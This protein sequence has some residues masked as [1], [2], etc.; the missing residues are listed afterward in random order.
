MG[1]VGHSGGVVP[2]STVRVKSVYTI[3][4]GEL[5][6]VTMTRLEVIIIY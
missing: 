1:A 5:K 6:S 3:I 4:S 2:H